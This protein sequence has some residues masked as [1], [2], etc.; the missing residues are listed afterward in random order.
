MHNFVVHSVNLLLCL[1]P[2]HQLISD[3]LIRLSDRY[4]EGVL[5]IIIS[6]RAVKWDI[7]QLKKS[8]QNEIDNTRICLLDIIILPLV[9]FISV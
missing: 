9:S 3:S 6:G 2:P 8:Q 4:W 5:F 1:T 7:T